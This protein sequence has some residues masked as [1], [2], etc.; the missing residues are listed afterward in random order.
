MPDQVII[1]TINDIANQVRNDMVTKYQGNLVG[2]CIEASER[3]QQM[4]SER[5]IEALIVP[6]WCMYDNASNCSDRPY[7][8]HTWCEAK[9]GDE[10]IYIDVTATQFQPFMDENIPEVI[11]GEMPGYMCYDEPVHLIEEDN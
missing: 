2:K 10:T 6:G 3:I 4:L 7:D 1:Q 11:I 5:G 9:V 8:E